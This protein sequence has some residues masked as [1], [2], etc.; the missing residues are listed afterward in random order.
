MALFER[1]TSAETSSAAE[2]R[3]SASPP[4]SLAATAA[5]LA[6]KR[7]QQQQAQAQ[8][9]DDQIDDDDDN[10]DNEEEFV[11]TAATTSGAARRSK[12]GKSRRKAARAVADDSTSDSQLRNDLAA[13]D[14]SDESASHG[15]GKVTHHYKGG[16]IGMAAAAASRSPSSVRSPG[17]ASLTGEHHA[18]PDDSHAAVLLRSALQKSEGR[19][20]YSTRHL[21]VAH[22]PSKMN[23]ADEVT[24]TQFGGGDESN[25]RQA[26]KGHIL[27]V[28][29]GPPTEFIMDVIAPLRRPGLIRHQVCKQQILIAARVLICVD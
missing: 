6:A 27:I 2:R 21:A 26:L 28:V 29:C 10:D 12:K 22:G 20:H 5:A 23:L 25:D 3:V 24:G 8:D 11:P 4:S 18:A 13:K 15:D 9:A 1:P 17:L 19:R 14:K 7:E 16:S